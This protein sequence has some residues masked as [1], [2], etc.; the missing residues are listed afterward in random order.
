MEDLFFNSVKNVAVI[1]LIAYPLTK[2]SSF[3][4]SLIMRLTLKDRVF[5][6]IIFGGFS[7]LGNLLGIETFNGSFMDSRIVGP[8]VGGIVAGPLAGILAGFIGGLHRYT[9]GGFTI[10]PDFIGNVLAGTISGFVYFIYGK[11]RLNPG[12][13][14]LTGLTSEIMLKLLTLALA[15][16]AIVAVAY[17]KMIGP[18]TILVNAAGIAIFVTIVQDVQ[19]NQNLIGANYAQKALEI[20]RRTLPI[21]KKGLNS[22]TADEIAKIIYDI[23]E[24][25]AVSITDGN[26]ILA[27]KGAGSDHHIPG[28]P[29][30][31]ELTKRSLKT[32]NVIVVYSREE[33][34]CSNKDCPFNAAMEAPL[35]FKDENVGFLKVY[36]VK[37]V[38]HQPDI[39]MVTGI[40]S[41]LST[42]LQYAK[43]DE[44][45][46]LLAKAEY[47]VLKAQINPH[48][49][50]NALSVIKLLIRTDPKQAQ[51]LIIN[52]A[53]FLRRTLNRNDDLLPFMQEIEVVQFYMSIQEARFGERLKFQM[54][55]DPITYDMLFP[56]FALQPLVEN[57]M[58]HGFSRQKGQLI[59]NVSARVKGNY[60]VVTVTDNGAGIP[61]E[62]IDAVGS[63]GK[64]KRLGIGLMNIQNRLESLYESRYSFILENMGNGSRVQVKIPII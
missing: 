10:L 39:S 28:E 1:A 48:F 54:D 52:L 57:S 53:S 63:G 3:R 32:D 20:A 7:I 15:K 23:S 38:F 31:T 9:M 29:L 61:L 37:D 49:L 4:R 36:K 13:I 14:F 60:L 34:G 45:A 5:L 42:Q 35:M 2:N 18:A 62:V 24:F 26:R 25:D 11:R 41:L 30:Q 64:G 40:A 50:F 59:L 55:V 56:T 16:P 22:V 44:Q 33:I 58:N 6:G 47:H 17:V 27:F 19:Y 12:I 51:N 8:V 21:L 46:K 43:L